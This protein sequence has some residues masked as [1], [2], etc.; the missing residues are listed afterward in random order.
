[1]FF[2]DLALYKELFE[3]GSIF[4]LVQINSEFIPDIL[5][6]C[7]MAGVSQFIVALSLQLTENLLNQVSKKN[8]ALIFQTHRLHKNLIKTN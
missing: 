3:H 5:E 1:M 7:K 8:F 4:K 2:S 6:Q